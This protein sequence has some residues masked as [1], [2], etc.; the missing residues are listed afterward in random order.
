MQHVTVLQFCWCHEIFFPSGP[1]WVSEKEG[2]SQRARYGMYISVLSYSHTTVVQKFLHWRSR[3]SRSILVMDKP[4]YSAPL[5][6][7]FLHHIFLQILYNICTHTHIYIC[8]FT[9]GPCTMT[10]RPQF[11]A[12]QRKNQHAL[13]TDMNLTGLSWKFQNTLPHSK[14]AKSQLVVSVFMEK[15]IHL[16]HI[17]ECLGGRWTSWTWSLLNRC[18][19]TSKIW[20]PI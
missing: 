12:H 8:W 10:S 6:R 11:H 7:L 13:Q 9:T 1:I 17:S 20:K 14:S 3:A 18:H 15:F 16:C 19:T 2:K 5:L 4:I